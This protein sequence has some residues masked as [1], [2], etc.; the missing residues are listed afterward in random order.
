MA[1]SLDE[2]YGDFGGLDTSPNLLKQRPDSVREGSKNWQWNYAD[3]LQ[4]RE[5][6][7][8]KTAVGDACEAGLIEYK[9][10]DINTGESRTET[11][12]VSFDGH[13][14]VKYVEKLKISVTAASAVTY[15]S[16]IYD[17]VAATHKIIFYNSSQASLGSV[18]VSLVM[19][20]GD[21][22]TGLVKAI[23][24]L[25]IAG[26]SADAVDEDNSSITSTALAYLMD[27]VWLE[28]FNKTVTDTEYNEVWLWLLINTPDGNPAFINAVAY[29][30]DPEWEGISYAN[31]NNSC[32]ITDGGFVFKYDGYSVYRAGMPKL[33]IGI[34]GFAGTPGAVGGPAL[35]LLATY[36]YKFKL[37]FKD[38]N[39]VEI[40]SKID[41]GTSGL[42]FTFVGAENSVTFGIPPISNDDQFP[43]YAAKIDG[44]QDPAAS[45]ATITVDAGHNIKAGMKLRIPISNSPLALTGFS[46]LIGS[47]T[48][49]TATTIT[50][51][52]SGGARDWPFYPASV[53]TFPDNTWIQAGYAADEWIGKITDVIADTFWIPTVPFGAYVKVYRTVAD[54]DTFYHL[55]DIPLQYNNGL[56]APGN[57]YTFIDVY[58]DSQLSRE[59]LDDDSGEELPRACKYLSVWQNQ[60]IQAGRPIDPTIKDDYYP[61]I[62]NPSAVTGTWGFGTT[63]FNKYLYGENHLCDFQSIYWEDTLNPEGFPQSGLNEESFENNFNDK[64]SGMA[65][66]KDTSFFVFKERTTAYLTGTLATGDI[67]KEFLEADIGCAT[68]NSI[69][70]IR[71]S[72]VFMDQNLGFWSVI[73]G[74]LP[75]FVGYPVQ[76]FFKRNK[77]NSRNTFLNFKRAKSTNFRAMDQYICYIPAGKKES[78]ESGL[79]PD[80]TGDSIMFILDYSATEGKYRTQWLAW[81]DI[82][83]AGGVLATAND[84]LLISQKQSSNNRLW[85]QKFTGSIYDYSDHTSAI[86]FRYLGAFLT[87]GK[88]VIDKHWIRIVL[89]AIAGGFD[90]TVKQF[91]NFMSDVIGDY[92]ISFPSSGK[93]TVKMDVKAVTPKLSGL[94]FGFYNNIIHQD[95]KIEGWEVEYNADFDIGEPKK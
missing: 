41:Y 20:L 65:Q 74:R 64:V 72:L 51:T 7:Q 2:H 87:L 32:Y 68:H 57:K 42:S 37:A 14:R 60:L 80:P 53:I 89:N 78:D 52:F 5:G 67:V 59:P 73:A 94:S 82:N 48:S 88:P 18:N 12:G 33:T 44:N 8:H 10:R 16:F 81:Q 40:L 34:D 45:P 9:F 39:G 35:T 38:P 50:Y 1:H 46:Y 36:K 13:L 69:Q 79:M 95:V 85:K 27:I 43:I 92:D 55:I 26:L 23:N 11:L 75:E 19:Q 30:D 54:G 3:Q 70:E 56:A 28:E 62:Y 93:N 6:F 66:N 91:G 21:A 25:A 58:T 71:G 90:L 76:D 49:V 24:D 29:K 77:L 61:T 22:T 84:E 31:H 4:K 47:V 17:S 63:E 86:D 83:A 15:Y